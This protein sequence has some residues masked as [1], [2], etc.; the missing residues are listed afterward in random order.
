MSCYSFIK[1]SFENGLFDKWIDMCYLLTMENSNRCEMYTYQLNKYK[2]FSTI[3]IQVN[4]GYKVCKK[5]LHKQISIQDINE[6]YLNVFQHAKA[7]NYNN[8]MIL[9]DDFMFDNTINQNIA[10]NIGKFINNN[11]YHIYNFGPIIHISSPSFDKNISSVHHRSIIQGTA[12]C[13]IYSSYYI[14][15]YIDNYKYMN[16]R[17][18]DEVWNNIKIIKYKYYKPLCYQIFSQ[19]ENQTNWASNSNVIFKLFC[20]FFIKI[21]NILQ[22][23]KKIKPG[24]TIMNIFGYIPFIIV[25]FVIIFIFIQFI[26]Q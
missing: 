23:N 26:K 14:D 24:F 12:H 3:I 9:E 18:V 7:N 21:I 11:N 2:P 22:L 4:K 15:H 10:D 6:S 16:D 25:V 13:V 17:G 19:T 1:L 5:N 20:N 8:I